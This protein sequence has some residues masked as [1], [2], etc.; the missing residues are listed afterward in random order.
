M[1]TYPIDK[2]ITEYGNERMTV[3]MTT[4]HCL[5]HLKLLHET[6]HEANRQ[7][8]LILKALEENKNSLRNLR[9]DVD[10]LIAHTKLPVKRKRDMESEGKSLAEAQRRRD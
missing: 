5:Q 4:G 2:I 7:R 6:D 10:A 9:A 1:A 3:E 8:H